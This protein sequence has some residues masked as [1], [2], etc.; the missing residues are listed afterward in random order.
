[1]ALQRNIVIGLDPIRGL[2]GTFSWADVA[3]LNESDK[4]LTS[5]Y[6]P[7]T[8]GSKI[9][10]LQDSLF[11]GTI[12]AGVTL[13]TFRGDLGRDGVTAFKAKAIT[14]RIDPAIVNRPQT[15]ENPNLN[16]FWQVEYFDVNPIAHGATVQY[17]R[18]AIEPHTNAVVWEDFKGLSDGARFA[19]NNGL[20]RWVHLKI[21]DDTEKFNKPVFG[22]FTL[23]YDDL[24]TR[25]RGTTDA[26]N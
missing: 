21:E 23:V 26:S 6:V 14:N 25:E 19:F 11:L 5:G 3:D 24:G 13:Q 12:N 7:R 20:A 15:V 2:T 9:S 16:R 22:G 4:G 1:M 17:T 10:L 8:K 18:D